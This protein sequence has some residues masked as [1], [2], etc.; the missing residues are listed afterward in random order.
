[1]RPGV[2]QLDPKSIT[3]SAFGKFE[4]PY[5]YIFPPDPGYVGK[6]RGVKPAITDTTKTLQVAPAGFL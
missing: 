6:I 2:I 1:L 4:N 5:C 3:T